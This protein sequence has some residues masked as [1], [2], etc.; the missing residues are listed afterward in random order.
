MGN[1][2]ALKADRKRT[3]ISIENFPAT[4]ETQFSESCKRTIIQVNYLF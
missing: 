2:E 1:L 4:A 3:H